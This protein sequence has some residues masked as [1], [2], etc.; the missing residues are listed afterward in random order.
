MDEVYLGL[1]NL[2]PYAESA[3]LLVRIEGSDAQCTSAAFVRIIIRTFLA[4]KY[5]FLKDFLHKL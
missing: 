4:A 1:S 5:I 2:G 3:T